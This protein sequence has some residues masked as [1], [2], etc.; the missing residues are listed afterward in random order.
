MEMLLTKMSGGR[1][2]VVERRASSLV[3]ALATRFG[4]DEAAV[5]ICERPTQYPSG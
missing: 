1:S 4:V 2:Y 3:P 5:E